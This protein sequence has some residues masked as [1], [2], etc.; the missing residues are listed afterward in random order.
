MIKKDLQS[1]IHAYFN[2]AK[3]FCR[4]GKGRERES[5][6]PP[7]TFAEVKCAPSHSPRFETCRTVP[8][9]FTVD[10]SGHPPRGSH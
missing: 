10:E 9:H 8:S 3:T 5:A 4:I 1:S 7:P 6:D 2:D